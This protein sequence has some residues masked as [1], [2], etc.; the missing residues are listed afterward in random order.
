MLKKI[1]I[2]KF[3]SIEDLTINCNDNFNVI[4]GENSIGKTSIFEAIHLW[5]MCYD[6]NTKKD[7]KGFYSGS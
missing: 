5:K 1:R 4:I 7:K 2:Q 6:W 3:K